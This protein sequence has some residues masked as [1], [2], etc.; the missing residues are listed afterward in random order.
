MT[1]SSPSLN[2][3]YGSGRTSRFVKQEAHHERFLCFSKDKSLKLYYLE[4]DK[5]QLKSSH[6]ISVNYLDLDQAYATNEF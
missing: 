2:I 3:I 6:I 5:Q 4:Q 1:R